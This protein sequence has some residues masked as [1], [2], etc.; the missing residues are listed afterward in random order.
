MRKNG[1]QQIAN[2]ARIA[3]NVAKAR[4]SRRSAARFFHWPRRPFI[5]D[6]ATNG[7][8]IDPPLFGVFCDVPDGDEDCGLREPNF[9]RMFETSS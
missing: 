8:D 9:P 5:R 1:S 7:I 4:F 2:V 3:N 6:T